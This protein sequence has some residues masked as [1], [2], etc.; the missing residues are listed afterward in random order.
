MEWISISDK[1]PTCDEYGE[2]NVLVCMD[3]DF[4]AVTTFTEDEGF[5][6]WAESGE[7]THWQPL[8]Q[9]PSGGYC[10]ED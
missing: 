1:L 8:P 9:P 10:A 6:L 5:I 3:D 2:V 4:M 7:V